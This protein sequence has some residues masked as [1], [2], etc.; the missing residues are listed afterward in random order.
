ML[1]P[2]PYRLMLILIMQ[3]KPQTNREYTTN[4]GEAFSDGPIRQLLEVLEKV[5]GPAVV[6]E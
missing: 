4:L 5:L 3:G 2:A 6:Q 1:P